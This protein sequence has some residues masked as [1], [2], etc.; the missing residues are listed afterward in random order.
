MFKN[1]TKEFSKAYSSKPAPA[2]SKPEN[3]KP[4]KLPSSEAKPAAKGGK[5][6]DAVG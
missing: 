1:V 6:T 2:N 4:A 3:A 5:N